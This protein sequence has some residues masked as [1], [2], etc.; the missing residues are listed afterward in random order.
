MAKR[1][2]KQ[3]KTSRFVLDEDR[4]LKDV[5]SDAGAALND[6]TGEGLT[7]AHHPGAGSQAQQR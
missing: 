7:L 1:K 3:Q 6:V 4:F 5:L 2:V